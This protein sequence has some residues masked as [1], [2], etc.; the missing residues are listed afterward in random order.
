[1]DVYQ[2]KNDINSIQVDYH[3]AKDYHQQGNGF[4]ELYIRD[5]NDDSS[6]LTMIS[7][8]QWADIVNSVND[9][10]KEQNGN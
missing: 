4:I 9:A 10:R 3:P 2:H 8:A 6:I 1:M 5:F 7:Y